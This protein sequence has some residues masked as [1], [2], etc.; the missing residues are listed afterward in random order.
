MPPRTRDDVEIVQEEAKQG[1]HSQGSVQQQDD[2]DTFTFDVDVYYGSNHSPPSP[3][4]SNN[5]FDMFK[6]R[7]EMRHRRTTS[8]DRSLW[9][10]ACRR[11]WAAEAAEQSSSHPQDGPSAAAPS[12]K[13][14]SLMGSAIPQ[15]C[16]QRQQQQQP[17]KRHQTWY[18]SSNHV[19]VNR[20]RLTQGLP[21]MMRSIALDEKARQVAEWAATG[22]DL[23]DMLQDED[24]RQF[25]SGNV[26]V[27]GSIREIH[28]QTLVRETCK[29]ERN[30][31]L[32]PEYREFG[33]GTYK[34]PKSGLLYMCQLFGTGGAQ[35]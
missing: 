15:F 35:V 4:K 2:D 16:N 12:R 27:G 22:K 7:R 8:R 21:P 23:K 14:N 1:D 29:R 3:R 34:D 30:N 33:M 5:D 26:L 31:L 10:R 11:I 13:H 24:A 19:L 9:H 6:S 17:Q 32:N 18:Y 20:E 28:G 25:V